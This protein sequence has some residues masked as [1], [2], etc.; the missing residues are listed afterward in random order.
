MSSDYLEFIAEIEI[1][2][3]SFSGSITLSDG[4]SF[5]STLQI[6]DIEDNYFNG[7]INWNVFNDLYNL[8]ELDLSDNF[9]S[10]TIDWNILADLA[11]N[12]DL[13]RINL[14]NNQFAGLLYFY[15]F[16]SIC[17]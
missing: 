9:F 4:L 5:S 10:G 15:F 1:G 3:N 17:P 14:Y 7:T 13:T 8:E 11:N 6:F 12:G 2:D 16:L